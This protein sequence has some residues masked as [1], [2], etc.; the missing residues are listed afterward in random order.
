MQPNFT[1]IQEDKQ[2]EL[3]NKEEEV[4]EKISLTFQMQPTIT[5]NEQ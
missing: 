5:L 1:L 2:N 4:H 3:S